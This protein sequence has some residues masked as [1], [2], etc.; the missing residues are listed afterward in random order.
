M[1][2]HMSSSKSVTSD[3][4]RA[5]IYL[6][7]NIFLSQEVEFGNYVLFS[8]DYEAEITYFDADIQK[9]LWWV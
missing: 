1:K 6:Q 8:Y 4:Q 5:N 2:L 3:E 7:A 9:T